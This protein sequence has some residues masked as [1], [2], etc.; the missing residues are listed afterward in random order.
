MQI[1]LMS[2]FYKYS[3]STLN[4]TIDYVL[5]RTSLS[6]DKINLIIEQDHSPNKVLSSQ[7]L[8]WIVKCVINN[9]LRFSPDNTHF[10]DGPKTFELLELYNAFKKGNR[11]KPEHKDINAFK[12]FQELQSIMQSYGNYSSRTKKIIK[13]QGPEEVNSSGLKILLNYKE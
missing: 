7:Y 13:D 12:T 2:W 8:P 1:Y 9:Q 10:E 5:T 11:L 4:K 6:K 3:Q